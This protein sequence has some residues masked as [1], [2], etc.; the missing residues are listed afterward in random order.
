MRSISI[1]T[2]HSSLIIAL[3]ADGKDLFS[4]NEKRA[5]QVSTDK[6]TESSFGTPITNLS[7]LIQTGNQKPK[8]PLNLC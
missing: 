3:A 1:S 8:N 6:L 7:G 4:L 2:K 5:F